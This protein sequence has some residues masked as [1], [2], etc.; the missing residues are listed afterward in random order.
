[1]LVMPRI[2]ILFFLSISFSQIAKCQEAENKSGYPHD[3]S[4][5]AYGSFI[6]VIGAIDFGP[7]GGGGAMLEYQIYKNFWIGGYIEGNGTKGSALF[8][9]GPLLRLRLPL[10]ASHLSWLISARG[11]IGRH[12]TK[13]YS[14]NSLFG[15]LQTSLVGLE[16]S[17][18]KNMGLTLVLP[19]P[20]LLWGSLGGPVVSSGLEIG[21]NY[22]W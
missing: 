8:H 4:S 12:L 13:N 16:W 15:L 19:T 5:S 6:F 21:F 3:L 18:A 20:N 10:P 22:L 1:M 7:V 9:G 11:G 14:G 17:F 2:L